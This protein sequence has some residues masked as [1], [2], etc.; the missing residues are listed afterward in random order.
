MQWAHR[1]A[2]ERLTWRGLLGATGAGVLLAVVTVLAGRWFGLD[3]DPWIIFA[4][5]VVV[6]WYACMNWQDATIRWH[7]PPG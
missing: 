7:V 1:N 5:L 6:A 3:L 2:P 4:G